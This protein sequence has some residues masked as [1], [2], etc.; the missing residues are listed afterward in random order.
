MRESSKYTPEQLCFADESAVSENSTRRRWGWGPVNQEVIISSD[1]NRTRRH[2]FLPL[3]GITGFIASMCIQDS[4]N[5]YSFEEWV[6]TVA[7]PAM[8]A[9]PLPC[10]VLVM[11]NAPI[12]K[13]ETI[14]AL[15]TAKGVVLLMLPPYSPDFNPIENA[16][17][18]FKRYLQPHYEDTPSARLPEVIL[19]ASRLCLTPDIV[20]NLYRGCGYSYAN[21]AERSAANA[22]WDALADFVCSGEA[23]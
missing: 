13:E 2:S 10:S 9:Y 6:E 23:F 1:F 15:C 22:N 11:D 17:G 19:E 3:L 8:N 7:L 5:E 4:F 14:R 21:D 18:L 20:E 16:F 12:H